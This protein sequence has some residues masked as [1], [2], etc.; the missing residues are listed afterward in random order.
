M[1]GRCDTWKGYVTRADEHTAVVRARRLRSLCHVESNG[2]RHAI[3]S[4][5]GRRTADPA[6][7][8]LIEMLGVAEITWWK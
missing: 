7:K 6:S 8:T 4:A 2:R 5:A 1:E 3:A